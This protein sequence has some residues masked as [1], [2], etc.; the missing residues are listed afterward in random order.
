MSLLLLLMAAVM[1]RTGILNS[2]HNICVFKQRMMKL[3]H[4][5]LSLSSSQTGSTWIATLTSTNPKAMLVQ[6]Y[7]TEQQPLDTT[8]TNTFTI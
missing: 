6:I 2:Y 5:A 3:T 4:P 8:V 7:R 1:K